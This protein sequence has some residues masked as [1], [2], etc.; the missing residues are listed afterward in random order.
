MSS[1]CA[2]VARFAAMKPNPMSLHSWLNELRDP[3]SMAQFLHDELPVRFAERIRWIEQI[4]EWDQI[5]ELMDAHDIHMD[6]FFYMRQVKP[7]ENRFKLA[8]KQILQK[9]DNMVELL[10]KSVHKLRDA[11]GA[12]GNEFDSFANTFMDDFLLSRLG[13]NS[14]MSQ[15]LAT[16][17]RS[18]G[19][20]DPS[21][22]AVQLCRKA[23]REVQLACQDFH[24]RQPVVQVEG[25]TVSGEAGDPGSMPRFAYIPGIL[26]FVMR[27]LL[28]NSYRATLEIAKCDDELA[29]RPVDIIVCVSEKHVMIRLS[30]QAQGIPMDVG[31]RVWSYM[32]T[33]A[34]GPAN[35]LAGHGV[36]LPLSRLYAR[37]L[38]GSLD[39]VSLPGYGTDAYLSLPRVDTDLKE[40]VPDDDQDQVSSMNYFTV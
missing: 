8:I 35:P 38:G 20:V 2:E 30:D 26:S 29:K 1:F 34:K 15:Y 37:Y 36:G 10:T 16:H 4:E 33:T 39:L 17:N 32:Y 13:C 9:E 11:R 18:T 6:A 25:Y 22:D 5:P 23:A 19:I 24:G 27:E 31:A 3:M 14:L 40:V 28:K 7:S 12:H 21:C